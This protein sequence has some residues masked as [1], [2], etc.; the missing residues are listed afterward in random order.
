MFPEKMTSNFNI[1]L[2]KDMVDLMA[3]ESVLNNY[4]IT[5][6]SDHHGCGGDGEIELINNQSENRDNVGDMMGERSFIDM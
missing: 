3:G 4:I 6:I 2:Y 5:D 1:D